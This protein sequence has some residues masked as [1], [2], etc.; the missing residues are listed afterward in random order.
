MQIQHLQSGGKIHRQYFEMHK[1]ELQEKYR[2]AF[3]AFEME[4]AERDKASER[5]RTESE[6]QNEEALAGAAT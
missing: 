1:V 5:A 3:R 2:E 6:R 4:M